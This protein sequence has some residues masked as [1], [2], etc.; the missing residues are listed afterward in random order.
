MLFDFS[1]MCL[2]IDLDRV[3]SQLCQYVLPVALIPYLVSITYIFIIVD[4]IS[5][6]MVP[7]KVWFR[8]SSFESLGDTTIYFFLSV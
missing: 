7:L 5:F 6:R 4:N 3:N 8:L 1:L 2:S